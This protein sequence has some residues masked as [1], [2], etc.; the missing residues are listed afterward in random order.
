MARGVRADSPEDESALVHALGD[1]NSGA[2]EEIY[3]RYAAHLYRFIYR[4]VGEQAED[5]EEITLDTFLSAID[6]AKTYA[7]RSSVFVW[8]CGIAKLRIIDHHRK[9]S[10]AKR[11]SKHAQMALDMLDEAMIPAPN[12][13]HG[14]MEEVLDRILASQV[15]EAALSRLSADEREALLLHY[16]E[17]LSVREIAILMKRSERG[18]ESVLTRAK[19]KPREYLERLLG[20]KP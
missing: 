2:A 6:L 19:A 10:S 13:G 9:Q 4:R 12:G 1:P 20:D 8:L 5:A 17:D 16:V 18:V 3:R 7:G 11:V 15:V 14:N